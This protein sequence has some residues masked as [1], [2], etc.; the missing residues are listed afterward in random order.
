MVAEAQAATFPSKAA[1]RPEC[2]PGP[3]IVLWPLADI[4]NEIANHDDLRRALHPDCRRYLPI[5][6]YFLALIEA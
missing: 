4:S 2:V 1:T 3:T 5:T 6:A